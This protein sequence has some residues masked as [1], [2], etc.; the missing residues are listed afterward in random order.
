MF[1]ANPAQALDELF[2]GRD[3]PSLPLLRL[4]DNRSDVIR[5]DLGD[6]HPLECGDRRIG[7]EPA[8]EV[9]VRRAVHLGRERTQPFLVRVRLG[10]HRQR[11]PRAAVE[12]A[13]ERDHALA[14]RVEPRELDRVLHRLGARV[15]ERASRLAADRRQHAEPF[16]ELDVALVRNHRVVRVQEAVG[17]LGDRRDDAGMVVAD[18]RHADAADEVD[19]RVAVDVGDR[20]SAGAIGDDRLV[21]DE[22]MRDRTLLAREDL[23]AARARDLRPDLD[24]AGRR[25]ARQP[26]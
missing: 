14:F 1:V 11:H 8:I 24:H 21:N 4:E 10:R 3:E 19:E 13:L 16:G 12:R 9:R 15:E 18:V 26:R 23:A 5:R 22:R 20:R 6:E 2:R 25:H 17:L 7:S